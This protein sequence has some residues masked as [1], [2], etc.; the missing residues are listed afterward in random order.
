MMKTTHLLMLLVLMCGL[1]AMAADNKGGKLQIVKSAA[2][3]SKSLISEGD[4]FSGRAV[5][6]SVTPKEGKTFIIVSTE[7]SVDWT[8]F[9]NASQCPVKIIEV[10]LTSG[11]KPCKLIGIY[12]K[13]GRYTD[14]FSSYGWI[15]RSSTSPYFLELVFTAPEPRQPL[16]LKIGEIESAVAVQPDSGE[17]AKL[18]GVFKI[19]QAVLLNELPS[20]DVPTRAREDCL[21]VLKPVT[22][23]LLKLTVELTAEAPYVANNEG[24]YQNNSFPL[25]NQNIGITLPDF[26]YIPSAAIVSNDQA[27]PGGGTSAR[28]N[29]NSAARFT[30]VFPVP[31]TI[32]TVSLL[33][34]RQVVVKDFKLD[35]SNQK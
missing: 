18:P 16:R 35:G 12:K 33:Y 28:P 6:H 31:D 24:L 7:L 34:D 11:N 19:T 27:Y 10:V 30:F 15:Q 17:P 14:F 21:A 13:G 3:F 1:P 5:V 32:S 9:T 20:A 2:W 22:G 26:G 25:N 29:S 23:K 8:G 4:G